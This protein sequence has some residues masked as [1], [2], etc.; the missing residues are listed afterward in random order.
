MVSGDGLRARLVGKIPTIE[1]MSYQDND[2][3]GGAVIVGHSDTD[4]GRTPT[5]DGVIGGR[6][7]VRWR[8]EFTRGKNKPRS[9]R[10]AREREGGRGTR[11][12]V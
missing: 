12:R 5:C 1:G 7:L 10:C 3:L 2:A 8:R 9:E 11:V 4:T 6:A